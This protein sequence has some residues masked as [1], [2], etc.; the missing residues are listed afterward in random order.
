MNV[1]FFVKDDFVL[2][3]FNIFDFV[4]YYSQFG[5]YIESLRSTYVRIFYAG[6]G[7]KIHGPV[8]GY[9]VLNRLDDDRIVHRLDESM[10]RTI[11]IGSR[12]W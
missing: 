9:T 2:L 6:L 4:R 8:D 10:S 7:Q 5:S 3:T 12:N 11:H 1:D